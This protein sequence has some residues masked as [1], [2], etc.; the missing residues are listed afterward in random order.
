VFVAR[1]P[2]QQAAPV[3]LVGVGLAALVGA[4]LGLREGVVRYRAALVLGSCGMLLAPLGVALARLLPQPPLLVAFA[5]LMLFAAARMARRPAAVHAA[6]PR[7][8]PVCRRPDTGGRLRWTW[9]CATALGSVG[10]VTGLLSGLLGVGGGFVIVPSLLHL[11][12]LDIRNI[13]ATSLAVIALVSASATGAAL[14]QGQ[15]SLGVALPFALGAA[16]GLVAGRRA[17][18]LLAPRMLHLAF[19]A[20]SAVVALMLLARAAAATWP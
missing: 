17:A 8:D 3:A 4:G 19:A 18:C 10:G 13:Q 16:L 9:R 20:T 11:S 2:M 6:R 1:L 15:L 12:N 14:W 5:A 7:R